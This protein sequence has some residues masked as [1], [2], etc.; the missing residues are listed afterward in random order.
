LQITSGVALSWGGGNRARDTTVLR[1]KINKNS[2]VR[3]KRSKP[4]SQAAKYLG[5]AVRFLM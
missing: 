4:K 5:Q 2:D 1:E 3:S